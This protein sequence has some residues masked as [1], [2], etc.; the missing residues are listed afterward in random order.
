[1]YVCERPVRGSCVLKFVSERVVC[2]SVVCKTV[3]V[4]K[5]HACHAN[6][7]SMSPNATPTTQKTPGSKATKAQVPRLLCKSDVDVTKCHA[8]HVN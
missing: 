8:C 5:C 2:E 3:D 6:A 1:M 4:T 7:M